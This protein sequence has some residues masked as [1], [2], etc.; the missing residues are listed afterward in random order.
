LRPGDVLSLNTSVNGKIEVMVGDM[1]KFLGKPG[2]RNKKAAVKI[3][4]IIR[5]EED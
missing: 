2:A 3:T 1:V 5:E 4:D